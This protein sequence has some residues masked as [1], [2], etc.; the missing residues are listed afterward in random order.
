MFRFM[1]FPEKF[2]QRFFEQKMTGTTREFLK[3]LEQ[4][5]P[6]YNMQNKY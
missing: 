2:R 1:P 5:F 4:T 3:K 6:L